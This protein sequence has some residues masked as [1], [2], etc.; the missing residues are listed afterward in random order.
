MLFEY[1][2]KVD[3]LG[4]WLWGELKAMAWFRVIATIAH[5]AIKRRLLREIHGIM[6]QE[7]EFFLHKYEAQ[8]AAKPN[9]KSVENTYKI[10][11]IN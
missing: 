1:L 3:S 4:K 5:L 9:I 11:N 10:Y 2:V 7:L 6:Y 8:V